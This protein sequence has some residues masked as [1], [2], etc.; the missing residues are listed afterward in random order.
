MSL[1][2]A[3]LHLASLLHPF[4]SLT[5]GGC[6]SEIAT[7]VIFFLSLPNRCSHSPLLVAF[8]EVDLDS[9]EEGGG[10]GVDVK[11]LALI[12]AYQADIIQQSGTERELVYDVADPRSKAT[13]RRPNCGVPLNLM[14]RAFHQDPGTGEYLCTYDL[15]DIETISSGLWVQK[16]FDRPHLYWIIRKSR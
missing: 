10:S 11:M 12:H 15:V 1:S 14:R 7:Y 16:D 2:V 8:V 13:A 3:Y 5:V 9:E 6:C 4:D